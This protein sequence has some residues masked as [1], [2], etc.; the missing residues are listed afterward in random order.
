MSSAASGLRFCGMIELPVVNASDNVMKS[1]GALHQMT[2]SSAR[3]ERWIAVIDAAPR[4]SSAKSRSDTASSELAQGR[5]KPSAAL[6]MAR[7]IGKDV[8]A[9]AA[10]PSGHSLS[11]ERAS[12][13]RPAVAREHLHISQQMVAERGRLRRLQMGEAGHD[14]GGVFGRAGGQRVH[15]R[16]QRSVLG[17]DGVAHPEAEIGRDLVIAAARGVQA[18]SGLADA[19]GQAR[20]DVH[21]HVFQR[22]V[23]GE[24]ARFDIRPQCR[25]GRFL[26]RPARPA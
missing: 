22:L 6:V 19:F 25:P 23:P 20:L 3:R 10:A 8:P 14:G 13:N 18:P 12:A 1:N 21:V 17:V 9:S 26:W 11:R 5:S 7:S 15:Q 24:H 2:I 4:Y 16:G